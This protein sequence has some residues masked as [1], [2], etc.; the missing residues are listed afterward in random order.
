MASEGYSTEETKRLFGFDPHSIRDQAMNVAPYTPDTRV[1]FRGVFPEAGRWSGLESNLRN[2][3]WKYDLYIDVQVGHGW[4]TRPVRF[5]MRGSV[6]VIKK[7]RTEVMA[8][9]NLDSSI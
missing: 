9:S 3:A 7:A 8:L 5:A 4:V 2:I 1:E 6:D